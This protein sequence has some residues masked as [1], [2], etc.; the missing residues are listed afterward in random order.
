VTAK[1]HKEDGNWRRRTEKWK[2]MQLVLRRGTLQQK[3]N[4][5]NITTVDCV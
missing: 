5:P 1:L 3:V 2:E 4:I